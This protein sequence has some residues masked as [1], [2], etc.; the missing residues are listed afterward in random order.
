MTDQTNF[1]ETHPE[2]FVHLHLHTQYSLL[3]GAIRI[4]DL[5]KQAK[6]WNV[7]A[8][9]QTDHGNMFGA[10]DFYTQC[11]QAGIKPILGSEIYF[12][13]GSRFD[14][15]PTKRSAS[16]SNQDSEESMRQIHHLILLCKDKEGYE[17]LCQLLTHAYLEGFYYKPRTDFELLKK[18]SKGLICTTACLK[19]EVGYN[20][21][22]DQDERAITAIEKLHG[23]FGDDFYLELQENGLAE[24][25]IVNEKIIKYAR[26]KNMNMVATNDCHYMTA[27]DATAQE[28]L[29]CIQ[30]GKTY[31]DENRMRMTSQEFYYKSPEK[32]RQSFAHV[33]E[34]CDN[35][36]KIA[37]KC[38][39]E[40]KFKDEQGRQIY[41]LPDYPIETDETVG[42]FFRRMSREGLDKRFK[43]PHFKKLSNEPN[44]ESEIKP[45]YTERLE[46]EIGMILQMGFPGYFL[47]VSDF[48]KW[49]KDNDIPVGPGR[50]S[51]AGSL[52]AYSL[53][54]TNV[55][56][57]PFNLLFERFINPERV[58]MPD[59]D[60][61]FCQAGRGRVIDYVT[62]KYGEERVGQIITFGK[63][64]AKAVIK[65]VSRVFGLTFGEADIISKL[66]PDELG[67]S[68]EDAL[69]KEPKLVELIESDPK[70]KQI[71]NISRRL[72][73][74]LRHASIHAAGV[75]ITNQPLV[76]YCPLFRGREGEKVV[77]FDKD[78]SEK[79]GLVKFD[80]LGLKTLT[81]INQAVKFI[82][83]DHMA[84]FDIESID[85][86]DQ[87]VYDY[88]SKGHTVGVFQLESSGMIELC[89]RIQPGTLD[90]ITAINA[91]YR[92]GPL[93]SGMVD[94]FIEIKHGRKEMKFPFPELE[95]VLKDTYG[96]V[97]YQEQVMNASRVVAGYSLGQADM[98]RR[99]MGKKK[100]EEMAKHR[101][102]FRQGA[103][104][105]G[106]NEQK[107]LELFD[108]MEKFAAYGFNKSHA[109]AYGLIAYQTAFLKYYYP[110]AFYAALLSS[111]I[112]NKDKITQYINDA[113]E[114]GIDV[115][116][117]HINE[118]LWHFN[119]VEGQVRIG[120][121]A[122]KNVGESAV[123]AILSERDKNGPFK[124]FL[125]FCDR[126]DMKSVNK[127]V[128]ESLI[129]V[130]AFD[131]VD[132][133]NR[134]T[135]LHNMERAISYSLKKQ[136]ERLLGQ[137]SLFDLGG[138][139]NP[140]MG[141]GI[142]FEELP[143]FEDKE[144]LSDEAQLLG[145]YVSGHPLDKVRDIV[146]QMVSMEI[147]QVH[148]AQGQDKRDMVLAGLITGKKEI[149]TKKGDKMCFAQLEDLSG[150]IE[151]IVF[152]RT[153]QEYAEI[154]KTDE[155]VI[156]TGKVNLSEEPRK[157][158]PE[159]IQKLE[160]QAEE[161]VTGVR[162][163]VKIDELSTKRLERLKQVVLS[164]RG[165]VP[166][167]VIFEAD[168]GKARIS[169]PE[170]FLVNPTPQ[171]AT[172]INE[173]FDRNIVQFI[174][175]GRLENV[176]TLTH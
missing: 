112:D 10:I 12:T 64:Q 160:D 150:K 55:D 99:A 158:F 149:I 168:Y 107:A 91:L 94:D 67:I 165:T 122:A 51:G 129:R 25:K 13:P 17:N 27:E 44:W 28:V 43:G 62:Q 63:L 103:I 53:D 1:I 124:S 65:D 172:K 11:K 76:S 155:P 163:S 97:V 90:D 36:L 3:D 9:A 121:G 167:H 109:V 16:V 130:G 79:I 6:E 39:V 40:L 85:L 29:L 15:K 152:P 69:E 138:E 147:A 98:L 92:P 30:T 33:P 73:G 105:K 47:I 87:N 48:I 66:I 137:A 26:E 108:T 127:R 95:P 34:A 20:F 82:R 134:R 35:T 72:E 8:I 88:I 100:A 120:M 146:R 173:V 175:D 81:V 83:R 143:D 166:M 148:E 2:S 74:L 42:D 151:C 19:G 171:M 119:V 154:L 7:P 4:P 37:D 5:I 132:G 174:V 31:A 45:K 144:K 162:I 38:N 93:E 61:D 50:G 133:Y 24:Q 77:Q 101:E 153:F 80:F 110:A 58:S 156:M 114:H 59:F 111:E 14:R 89:K 57:I 68:L 139:D 104:S 164:Y 60:V 75:I 56:P 113:R 176:S 142:D 161:R 126:V 118:S 140:M 32:M 141:S 117:P 131:N 145:I 52:V 169:L 136:E 116:A 96:V 41:H 54:I 106:F 102:I 128:I 170:D 123:G 115:L 71:F 23:I 18:F 46:E 125:D 78:F 70:I 159:K 86:E 22:T 84:D 135:L 21:F 49:A 157:F